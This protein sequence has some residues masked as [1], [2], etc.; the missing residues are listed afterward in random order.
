MKNTRP[1][2]ILILTDDQGV[3]DLSCMGHPFL[4]TPHMDSLAADG[5]SFTDFHVSPT[6]APTRASIM[7][8]MHEFYCGVTHTITGRERL[9]PDLTILPQVLKSAGYTTGIFGKWHLGDTAGEA[10]ESG[11]PYLPE[12]RGFDEVF[13]HGGGGIGQGFRYG[14]DYVPG[15]T[16]FDPMIRHNGSMVPTEGFCTDVFFDQ[17][18]EWIGAERDEPFFAYIPTNA[19]HG[20]LKWCPEE[21]RKRYADLDVDWP[22]A[23]KENAA[24]YF[25]MVANIDDNVGRLLQALKARR[26]EENTLV[27]FITDNGHC[28]VATKVNLGLRG[29]KNC[30][31]DG[32]TKAASLWRW[33]GTIPAG[34]EINGLAA[35]IDLLPTFADLAG[36]ELPASHHVHGRSLVPLLQD[37]EAS[38]DDRHFFAHCGRWKKG[39]TAAHKHAGCAVRNA[40]FKLVNNAELYDLP[41]DP[42]ETT[43]VID[44]HPDVV[45]ELRNA[46]DG[47]WEGALA[48]MVN[49]EFAVPRAE[50]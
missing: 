12:S 9:N 3:Q 23:Q 28:G 41:N 46:Y 1:N 16:Y 13:V 32:G 22:D 25:G 49:E 4:R 2:I 39:E 14:G 20:P 38:W 8:G 6:C 18:I 15:Q 50:K 47:W 42:G 44:E 36:A 24:I 29:G 27:I 43:N 11:V 10:E 34:T 40:R 5:V 48:G 33:E 30:P 26:L 21:A 37:P 45:C 31:Y 7:S 35:H 19:P 17:A